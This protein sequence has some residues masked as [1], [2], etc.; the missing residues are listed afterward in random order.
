MSSDDTEPVMLMYVDGMDTSIEATIMTSV[1]MQSRNGTIV[2]VYVNK[3]KEHQHKL[4]VFINKEHS[5][6]NTGL[7]RRYYGWYI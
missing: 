4:D 7:T 6:H 1:V 3:Y 2:E 5:S